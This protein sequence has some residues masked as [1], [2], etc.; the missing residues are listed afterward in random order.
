MTRAGK[1][2]CRCVLVGVVWAPLPSACS[3][4]STVLAGPDRA[5]G[6]T[7]ADAGPPPTRLAIC[8]CGDG[9]GIPGYT[10]AD[11]EA[12]HGSCGAG[13]CL[14]TVTERDVETYVA[15]RDPDGRVELEL[16]AAASEELRARSPGGAVADL[17][18]EGPFA[19][20]LDGRRLYLGL[21]Y[22]RGGAAALRF[23][24]MHVEDED[25]R[26]R[27]RVGDVQGRWVMGAG[28]D[29]E[30]LARMDP[31]ELRALFAGLGKYEERP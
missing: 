30:D 13:P 3:G 7:I 20:S 24:V 14:A 8:F 17:F 22:F 11:L 21:C 27:L 28:G 6:G 9:Y 19:V 26:V 29:T 10:Y 15:G 18:G 12:R 23:P 25:G 31:A 2:V 16:T 1:T 5:A 4:G